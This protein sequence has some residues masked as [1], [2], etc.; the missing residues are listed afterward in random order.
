MTATELRE[1]FAPG[2]ELEL[3][4]RNEV[5]REV[6]SKAS[7]VTD[8]AG[9]PEPVVGHLPNRPLWLASEIREFARQRRARC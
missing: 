8:L 9:L 6:G 5:A 1:Q 7:N 3:M 2:G 4:G